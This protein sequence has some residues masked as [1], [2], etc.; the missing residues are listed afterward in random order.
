[1]CTQ[2]AVD[3]GEHAHTTG[4][5]LVAAV[6]EPEAEILSRPSEASVDKA[7]QTLLLV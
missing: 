4:E 1:M 3:S 2:Q 6:L 5:A 7:N